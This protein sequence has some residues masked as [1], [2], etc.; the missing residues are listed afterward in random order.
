MEGIHGSAHIGV[1]VSD[2]EV[3]KKFYRDILDFDIIWECVIGTDKVA[4]A[5][6]GDLTL[7]LIQPAVMPQREDGKVDHIALGVKNIEAVH[8][9]LKARGVTFE[10]EDI[11]FCDLVFPN[12]AKWILFR[13]PDGERLELN[14]VL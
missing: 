3:S 9:A 2:L 14:E 6:T 10:T 11:T 7:E 13:G 4:F 5:R 12:G 8:A 1:F